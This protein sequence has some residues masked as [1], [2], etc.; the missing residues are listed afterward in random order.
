V[1]FL[2]LFFST[3]EKKRENERLYSGGGISAFSV[4][5]LGKFLQRWMGFTREHLN[6]CSDVN[7]AA[8]KQYIKTY[9]EEVLLAIRSLAIDFIS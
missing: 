6:D 4:S 9:L 8:L 2:F 3:L 5:F 7:Y 1:D